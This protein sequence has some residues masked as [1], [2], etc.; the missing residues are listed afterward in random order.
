LFPFVH[1][2]NVVAVPACYL[3]QLLVRTGN[4]GFN[5]YACGIEH[6]GHSGTLWLM[7]V[8]FKMINHL[9]SLSAGML[10]DRTYAGAVLA[11]TPAE[12]PDSSE[13]DSDEVANAY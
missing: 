8:Y 10:T 12:K 6:I 3:L 5:F 1:W 13:N 2:D 7:V 4:F 9:D 11:P